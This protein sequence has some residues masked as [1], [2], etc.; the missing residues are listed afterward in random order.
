MF[1]NG[2]Q[3]DCQ[4]KSKSIANCSPTN[5]VNFDSLRIL[6][7]MKIQN[8][9]KFF[10]RIFWKKKECPKRFKITAMAHTC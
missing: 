9:K 4:T 10:K 7:E 8:S 5:A 3:K 1:E 2:H 6:W